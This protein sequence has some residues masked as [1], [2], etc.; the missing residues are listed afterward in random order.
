[1][2]FTLGLTR[3]ISR[4][5]ASITSRDDS[6]FSRIILAI[7]VAFSEQSSLEVAKP[8]RARDDP[9]SLP[10]FLFIIGSRISRACRS[11][12]QI[13]VHRRTA[14]YYRPSH[15][16]RNNPRWCLIMRLYQSGRNG[17]AD[18]SHFEL[19]IPRG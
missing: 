1:M 19:A 13:L 7:S 15:G 17:R 6:F 5:W 12:F 16:A 2:A 18:K 14:L 10:A 3:S 8:G 11:E 4:K 9:D